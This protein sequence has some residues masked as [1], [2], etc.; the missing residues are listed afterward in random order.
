MVN[1][2]YIFVQFVTNFNIFYCIVALGEYKNV[3]KIFTNVLLEGRKIRLNTA[4]RYKK[5]NGCI[6]QRLNKRMSI[7]RAR[8]RLHAVQAL[9]YFIPTKKCVLG[10]LPAIGYGILIYN[11]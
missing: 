7:V 10:F 2:S 6:S 1:P 3:G 8:A 5:L 4:K 9:E 11:S